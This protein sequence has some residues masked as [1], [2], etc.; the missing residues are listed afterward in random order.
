MARRALGAAKESL[1]GISKDDLARIRVADGE[2]PKFSAAALRDDAHNAADRIE[3]AVAELPLK[4]RVPYSEKFARLMMQAK[5]PSIAK[6]MK[7]EKQIKFRSPLSHFFEPAVHQ[8]F[9]DLRA[10]VAQLLHRDP[11]PEYER[12]HAKRF[13]KALHQ[14]FIAERGPLPS[15]EELVGQDPPKWKQMLYCFLPRLR[16]P[17]WEGAFVRIAVGGLSAFPNHP[18][19]LSLLYRLLKAAPVSFGDALGTLPY[20]WVLPFA[21]I[22]PPDMSSFI[23]ESFLIV[24]RPDLIGNRRTIEFLNMCEKAGQH[25]VCVPVPVP[26]SRDHAHVCGIVL[27]EGAGSFVVRTTHGERVTFRITDEPPSDVPAL[28]RRPYRAV[29]RHGPAGPGPAIHCVRSVAERPL[30]HSYDCGPAPVGGCAARRIVRLEVNVR[31]SLRG[32]MHRS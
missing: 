21:E 26:L 15:A 7:R 16:D 13:R 11:T 20:E 30:A 18:L 14:R 29:R 28:Y 10:A 1:A 9:A 27:T 6:A 2:A 24:G 22:E 19:F 12:A 17:A 31:L 23:P 4:N 8:T 3:A 32:F 25:T 5:Y